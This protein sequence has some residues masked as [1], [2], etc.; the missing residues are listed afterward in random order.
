[1]SGSDENEVE[2]RLA[3]LTPAQRALLEQRLMQRQ[4]DVAHRQM[5]SRRAVYSPCPL[6]YSQELLWLLSQVFDDGVAYNA[7][8]TFHLQ[9]TLDAELLAQSFEALVHRHEILRTTYTVIDGEPMQVIGPGA[10][11]KLNLIDLRALPADEREA[12][13]QRTLKDESRFAFDLVNGPVIRPTLFLMTDTEQL[14][15][16]NL[17]HVATDG[18]SRAALCRDLTVFYDAIASGSEPAL[19]AL[20]IQ[21]ADFAVWHRAWLDGGVAEAQLD[22]WKQR[23][24][25]APSHLDLPSDRSRP[26]VRSYLGDHMSTMLDMPTR[27]GLAAASRR[28]EA[29]PFVAL[30]A[31]FATLLARYSG[32]DDVVIG[33]PFAGRNRTEL[34][35]MVGYF[36]NP[37]A[38]RVDLSGDP[39][40]DELIVR[41]RETTH[42]AFANADVPYEMIVRATNPERDLSQTPVFQAMIVYHNPAWQTER[43][44]FEPRGIRCTEISHEKGWSKFD[45][46]LG[47]SERKLGMNTTWE[48]STELF[49]PATVERMMEHFR[50][51]AESAAA[52]PTKR[53][54]KLSMLS[55]GERAKV[56]VSWNTP[57][58]GLPARGSIKSLFEEQ[59]ARTPDAE[60]VVFR[61]RRLTFAE[62]N[63]WANRIANRLREQGV[64]PGT[65][66]GILM[67]KSLDLVPTVLGVMKA[68]AAYLPLDPAYPPE[69]IAFM[70]E[71][72]RPRLL[73]A[74][75][76]SV[77]RLAYDGLTL[78]LDVPSALEG[79]SDANPTDLAGGD[80]LAYVI[81]TSGSTGI[82]KGVMVTNRGLMSVY[83]AYEREYRLRE[84]TAHAQVASFSFDV[85]TGDLIRALLAGAKVV[86]CPVDTVLDPPALFELFVREGVD[87]VELVP[88]TASLLFEYAAREGKRLDFMRFI[89]I[90][91]EGWRNDKYASFRRLCGAGTRLVNSYGLTEATMD[92]TY[93]EPSSDTELI[94]GRFVPAGRPLPNT[95]VYVLDPSLEPQPVGIPGELYIGGMGVARGYL[96]RDDLTAE[97]FAHDPFSDEP[98]ARMYRTGDLA[99]WLPDGNLEFVGRR[100]RQI[101]IRGFRVEPGEIESVLERHPRVR[102]AAVIDHQDQ[103]GDRRLVAYLE[104][105][106]T[107]PEVSVLRAFAAEQVPNYMV[108]SGYVVLDELPLN[109]NGKVDRDALPEPEWDRAAAANEFVAPQTATERRVAEIWSE[110]LGVSG[111]GV[112][113]N[114]FALGGHSILAMRV[115]ARVQEDLGTNLTLRAV[116]D[117]PTVAT[118]AAAVDAADRGS[119]T[120]SAP[121][122]VRVSRTRLP[123][124]RAKP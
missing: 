111:V 87:A 88:A 93:F 67:E 28:S 21:Y 107:P 49:R 124:A 97:R 114:F 106:G 94:P 92:S 39:T 104:P 71:D 61:Q 120:G 105:N 13:A 5:I 38:L 11:V 96:N 55:E 123:S 50:S 1:M 19:P 100:D 85:F 24:A 116:F 102:A 101:K 63:R 82:P 14:L 56:L 9:G 22:Y 26:P 80:D 119:S 32:Q 46:L 122:L 15:M 54:S 6:S 77:A 118:L 40:F 57:S 115:M 79:Q 41:A 117:A 52:A 99:R 42:D 27:E 73:L 10:P 112:N 12:E 108:P 62:L 2:R 75:K 81:Y 25:G 90:G 45:V 4:T 76:E 64:G 68:G 37:L 16:F 34:E 35:S 113:D 29:T 3:R 98:G 95:R 48:Y 43:P 110:V 91:G 23:L 7:P 18:Y 8:I 69:R 44:K 72:A 74:H 66:V 36:I 84:L 51:L 59:A 83:L 89:A 31:L 121:P 33:T 103:S 109:P 20:P 53:L 65:L 58:A 47:A 70:L 86:I 60:A 17:H 78:A 30:L